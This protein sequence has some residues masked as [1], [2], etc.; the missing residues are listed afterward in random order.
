[1][2]PKFTIYSLKQDRSQQEVRQEVRRSTLCNLCCHAFDRNSANSVVHCY[3]IICHRHKSLNL[4]RS[5]QSGKLNFFPDAICGRY[6]NF[7][8]YFILKG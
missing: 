7:L 1:M 8:A 6:S 3:S 4:L 5:L 2:Q